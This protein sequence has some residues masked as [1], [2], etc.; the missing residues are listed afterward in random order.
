MAHQSTGPLTPDELKALA[1]AP[2]GEAT[3]AIRKHDPMFGRKPGE[4]VEWQLLARNTSTFVA[5]VEA[6]TED[7][8]HELARKL[9]SAEWDFY[10]TN[11]SFEILSVEPAK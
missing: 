5:Y 7:E 11:K 10:S 9:G 6:E 2:Y 3:K 1:E 4:K 8:A